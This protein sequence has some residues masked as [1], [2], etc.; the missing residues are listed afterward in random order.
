VSLV[1][2]ETTISRRSSLLKLG[3]LLAGALGAA[4]LKIDSSDGAGPAGVASGAVSCVLTPE[5]TEGPYYTD[6]EKLR[7]NITEGRPGV[8]MLLRTFVVDAS[9]CRPIRSAA[10]DIWHAD[11]GGIYS[12]FGQG[13]SNRTFMR[14]IQK[15]NAKG[16]AQFRTVYP[17]WYQGRTVHIH[18]KVHLGGNVVHTG[19]LYFPDPFTDRVYRKA[20]YTARPS[21]TTRNVDDAIY[22]NGGRRSLM[23][24]RRTNAGLYV[25]TITMGVSRS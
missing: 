20:P 16:L 8:A 19:Q 18:V 7:R 22:R 21:R 14:G 12:G 11:A 9:T 25:A 23:A 4:G 1:N 2:D 3:G 5:Q 10:V 13:S 24:L 6:G 17:G 15:T